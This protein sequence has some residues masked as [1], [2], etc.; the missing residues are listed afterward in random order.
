VSSASRP[1][2]ATAWT[3]IERGGGVKISK[4]PDVRFEGF[5][6]LKGGTHAH[7]GGRAPGSQALDERKRRFLKARL[8]HWMA[9]CDVGDQASRRVNRRSIAQ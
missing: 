6:P 9:A 4:G 1:G 2:A 5:D 7:D 8:P 3:P